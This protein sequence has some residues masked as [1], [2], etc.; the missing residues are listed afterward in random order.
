VRVFGSIPTQNGIKSKKE[1]MIAHANANI[2]NG[3]EITWSYIS[4]ATPFAVRREMLLSKYGFTCHCPRCAM[5]DEAISKAEFQ[6]LFALAD[7]RWSTRDSNLCDQRETA[8]SLVSSIER[9]FSTN[10]IP[11]ESQRYL[12]V[13][14]GLVRFLWILTSELCSSYCY[15]IPT[16]V[17]H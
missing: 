9:I 8:I 16:A 6:G 2:P 7:R 3:T 5:E 10:Q 12:R 4:P 1:V 17:I 13:S 11:I 14:Y 15:L